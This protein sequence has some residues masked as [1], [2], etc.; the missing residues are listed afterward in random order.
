MSRDIQGGFQQDPAPKDEEK[1]NPKSVLDT[2]AISDAVKK[3]FQSSLPS[4]IKLFTGGKG[5]GKTVPGPA[6]GTIH[7]T[8]GPSDPSLDIWKDNSPYGTMESYECFFHGDLEE[9]EVFNL[10]QGTGKKVV[11]CAKCTLK[12][13]AE[14][15]LKDLSKTLKRKEVQDG[16]P[17]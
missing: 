8:P 9:S 15:G 7:Y 3:A 5:G 14:L 6:G 2:D 16:T 17:F 1:D 4:P 13:F 10:R 12:A 11:L